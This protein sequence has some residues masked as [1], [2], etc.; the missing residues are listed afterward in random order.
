MNAIVCGGRF[1]K[2]RALV[3][4]VLDYYRPTFV[5]HGAQTGADT[6]AKDWANSRGVAEHGEEANWTKYRRA[7]GPIRNGKML[8]FRPAVV[9]A[10]PG[11]TGTAD[12]VQ[13]ARAAG[14]MVIEISEDWTA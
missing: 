1:Y 5:I 13:Q 7:A 4:S 12:M 11:N 14:I 2:N 6:L 9:I 8:T 3:Y 10:F